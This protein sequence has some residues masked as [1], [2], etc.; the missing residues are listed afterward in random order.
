MKLKFNPEDH[1]FLDIFA[2]LI[3]ILACLGIA[4]GISNL[5]VNAIT[6]IL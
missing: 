5:I 2:I 1:D 3:I 6:N 4:W